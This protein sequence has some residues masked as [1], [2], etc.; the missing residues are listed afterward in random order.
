MKIGLPARAQP[1]V[2]Y[3]VA[4]VARSEHKAAAR[5]WIRTLLA[6]RAQRILREAGFGA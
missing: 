3:E 5:A 4:V 2:R 1:V 6:P